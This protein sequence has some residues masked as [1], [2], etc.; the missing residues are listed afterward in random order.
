MGFDFDRETLQVGALQGPA[1][2]VP[3]AVVSMHQKFNL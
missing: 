1:E 2:E 3:H